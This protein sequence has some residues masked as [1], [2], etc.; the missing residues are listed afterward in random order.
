MG[1]TLGLAIFQ[2]TIFIRQSIPGLSG[3]M[4]ER[5][6]GQWKAYESRVPYKLFP[7]II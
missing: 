6:G 1:V 7:G 2:I 5:Y 4:E 3:H